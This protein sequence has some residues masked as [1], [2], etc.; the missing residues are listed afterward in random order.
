LFD[1]PKAQAA[2]LASVSDDFLLQHN[3][4]LLTRATLSE[5]TKV[6]L[7]CRSASTPTAFYA[8][9]AFGYQG[10]LFVD[11]GEHTYRTESGTGA[12][13]KLSDPVHTSYPSL[14]AAGAVPWSA[15]AHKRF[16]PISPCFAH[17]R[18]LQHFKETNG[19]ATATAA[20]SAALLACGE[21]LVADNGVGENSGPKVALPFGEAEARALAAT[22]GAELSPVCAVLGGVIGQEVVKFVSGKGAPIFN[23]FALNALSGEGKMFQSPP[24]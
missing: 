5:Q 17:N 15:L 1:P 21:K 4:V 6:D 16:G 9:D 3:I 14:A 18:I 11:L 10:L 7:L 13:S 22:A 2:P 23:F 24:K 8:A 12:D 19:G 20:D